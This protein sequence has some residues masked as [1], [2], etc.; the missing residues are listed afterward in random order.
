MNRFGR[1]PSVSRHHTIPE[2]ERTFRTVGRFALRSDDCRSG[3]LAVF[4]MIVEAIRQFTFGETIA[5]HPA[6]D[7]AEK[8]P[9]THS[10]QLRANACGASHE[11]SV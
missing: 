10:T 8:W 2:Y 9:V 4:P 11:P 5:A 6:G 3:T 7:S 1:I